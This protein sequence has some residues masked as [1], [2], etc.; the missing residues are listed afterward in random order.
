MATIDG[1]GNA[2]VVLNVENSAPV[3]CALMSTNLSTGYAGTPA[4]ACAVTCIAANSSNSSVSPTTP[5]IGTAPLYLTLWTA[6]TAA[7]SSIAAAVM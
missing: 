4:R 3:T 6:L 5:H 7:S 2:G 1:V